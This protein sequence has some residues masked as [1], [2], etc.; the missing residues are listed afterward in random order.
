MAARKDALAVG[1]ERLNVVGHNH[2]RYERYE[3]E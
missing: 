3:R 2:E 1:N